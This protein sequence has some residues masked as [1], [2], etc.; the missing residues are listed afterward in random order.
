MSLY[1]TVWII[2][3]FLKRSTALG[4]GCLVPKIYVN[5]SQFFVNYSS[6]NLGSIITTVCIYHMIYFYVE[7]QDY[8]LAAIVTV[9]FVW[10]YNSEEPMEK[11]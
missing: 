4:N 6:Y 8:Y 10:I 1:V 5:I 11:H 2:D 7:F 3:Y 9:N